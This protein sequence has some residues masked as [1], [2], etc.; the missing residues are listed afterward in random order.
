MKDA[1]HISDFF[2]KCVLRLHF[3]H[4]LALAA[5]KDAAHISDRKKTTLHFL[6]TKIEIIKEWQNLEF[7][8]F[9]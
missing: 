7:A 2:M 5:V 1:M 6:P 3:G 8:N 4:S 9:S